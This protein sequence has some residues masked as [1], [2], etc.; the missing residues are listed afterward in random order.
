MN[1]VLCVA[2]ES[3]KN[4]QKS[5]MYKNVTFFCFTLQFT[6]KLDNRFDAFYALQT[7]I[8]Q[9]N[10]LKRPIINSF[11]VFCFL[12]LLIHHIHHTRFICIMSYVTAISWRQS[13]VNRHPSQSGLGEECSFTH[14]HLHTFIYS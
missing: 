3:N 7:F 9:Y 10:L 2:L 12:C 13:L 14:V 11:F 4:L 8:T 6:I 5:N 1:L